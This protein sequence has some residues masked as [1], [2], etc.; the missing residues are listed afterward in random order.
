MGQVGYQHNCYLELLNVQSLPGAPPTVTSLSSNNGAIGGEE[1]ITINGTG[2]VQ[3]SPYTYVD[4][5]DISATFQVDSDTQ[6]T[7][8]VPPLVGMVDVRVTTMYGTSPVTPLCQFTAPAATPFVPYLIG[9]SPSSGTRKGGTAVTLTGGAFS[10]DCTV[11]IGGVEATEVVVAGLT[12]I[13]AVTPPGNDG[14]Y[15]VVVTNSLG[16]S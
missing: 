15:E 7:A 8:T 14:E 11:T 1:S 13:T 10:P 6:I 12:E 3:D 5:G 4:F 2:F 9:I 16:Q